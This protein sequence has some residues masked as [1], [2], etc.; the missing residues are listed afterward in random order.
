MTFLKDLGWSF[1]LGATLVSQSPVAAQESVD[2]SGLQMN[3]V[4]THSKP[5]HPTFQVELRNTG[6]HDFMLNLGM[7]LANGKKQYPDAIRLSLTDTSG[8]VLL[9]ELIGPGFIAG[10]VDPLIVPLPRG[11]TFSLPVDMSDYSS[12]KANVWKLNF[13]PGQYILSANY[14]GKAVPATDANLDMKGVAL[15]PI[16]TGNIHSANLTFTVPDK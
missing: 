16:W 9:L 15:L 2:N 6:D 10:R 8:S 7:M 12:P 11:A 13:T 4:Q 1:I 14:T 5:A 3:L